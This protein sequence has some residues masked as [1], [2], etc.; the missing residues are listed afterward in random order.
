MPGD[1]AFEDAADPLR[2]RS[3]LPGAVARRL[4]EPTSFRREFFRSAVISASGVR[5]NQFDHH[6]CVPGGGTSG[7]ASAT[8]SAG[9]ASRSSTGATLS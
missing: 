9:S 5:P 6:D 3:G 7:G 8:A 4:G 1:H 2:R